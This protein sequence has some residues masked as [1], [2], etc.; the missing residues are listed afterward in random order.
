[1]H[2]ILIAF[3]V[4]WWVMSG[5][6]KLGQFFNI[7]SERPVDATFAGIAL[8]VVAWG[9][10]I[11]VAM[12]GGLILKATGAIGEDMRPS[13]VIPW[14]GALPIWQRALIVLSAMTVE[15]LFFRGWLQ[16]RVGLIISTI[17]FALAHAGYG[18]PLLLV[19]VT[20]VSLIIGISFYKTKN[21]IPCIIAHGVFDAIQLFVTVPVV[22][23]MLP[24]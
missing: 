12:L 14:M 9:L 3:L 20:V 23:K 1:M 5:R 21:L 8:G 2:F 10:T 22:M 6:P 4:G 11:T 13:P 7:R 18:Q 19:G 24:K 17:A 15:E 16:K